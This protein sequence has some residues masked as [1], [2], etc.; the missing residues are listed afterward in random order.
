MHL[1]SAICHFFTLTIALAAFGAA[2]P[3]GIDHTTKRITEPTLK[4]PNGS[5]LTI[6]SGATLDLS[7]GTITLPSSVV[8]TSSGTQTIAGN[9][10][11]S[12]NQTWSGQIAGTPSGGTLDLGSLT[13]KVKPTGAGATSRDVAAQIQDI[14]VNVV[15]F[16]ADPTGATDCKAHIDDA[17]TAANLGAS[18]YFPRGNYKLS[19]TVTVPMGMRVRGSGRSATRVVADDGVTAF[20][21]G[22]NHVCFEDM[23]VGGGDSSHLAGCAIQLGAGYGNYFS[24]SRVRFLYAEVGLKNDN[25][26]DASSVSYCQFRECT[27]GTTQTT[28]VDDFLFLETSFD[29]CTTSGIDVNGGIVHVLHGVFGGNNTSLRFITG[30]GKATIDHCWLEGAATTYVDGGGNSNNTINLL[31]NSFNDG[32]SP[33]AVHVKNMYNGGGNISGN[34]VANNS[35][36]GKVR[37]A[38]MGGVPHFLSEDENAIID[39]NGGYSYIARPYRAYDVSDTLPTPSETSEHLY[40]LNA[41]NGT[42]GTVTSRTFI[43]RQLGGTWFY[44]AIDGTAAYLDSDTDGTLAANSDSKIATQKAVKTYA[45]AH[46]PIG[47]SYSASCAVAVNIPGSYATCT[48]LTLTGVKAGTYQVIFKGSVFTNPTE[49]WAWKVTASAG[50]ITSVGYYQRFCTWASPTF[51]GNLTAFATGEDISSG[52]VAVA[53]PFDYGAT[54]TLSADADVTLQHKTHSGTP[55]GQVMAGT[56]FILIKQ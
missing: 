20:I 42:V 54:I 7:A 9:K 23:D 2:D 16:G 43:K 32:G 51:D 45:D 24:A 11:W 34:L 49:G 18:L 38:T 5:T 26:F 52:L 12:G 33:T 50:S 21:A 15:T 22:G 30:G 35:N 47:A 56:R 29:G 4:L 55:D 31:S 37:C 6:E 46:A 19:S 1:K 17:V 36:W 40:E 48:G 25:G 3:L 53:M 27:V 8:T 41:W 10:T 14:E 44:T 28:G 13:L 39:D